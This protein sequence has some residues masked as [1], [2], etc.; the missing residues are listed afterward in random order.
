M[1]HAPIKTTLAVLCAVALPLTACGG[2]TKQAASVETSA[3]A[4][5]SPAEA[6]A[7]AAAATAAASASAAAA[8]K[9]ADDAAAKKAADDAAAKKAADDAA[10]KKAADD[11][12]AAEALKPHVYSGTGDDVLA[13]AKHGTGAEVLTI[14][15]NGG[16]NFAVEQLD[17]SMKTTGLLVNT[18]GNYTGTVLLD[19][20]SYKD[21][22]TKTLKITAGGAWTITATP[23]SALPKYD[24]SVPITGT[25]DSVFN[26]TGQARGATF[27]HNG[28]HNVAV[29]A[30]TGSSSGPDLL[31]N[32]I[33]TYTG[34]VVWA[35]GLYVVTADGDW[36]ATIK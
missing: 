33:G 8:K 25:G 15:H 29:E 23:T 34:T 12:A 5:V 20:P 2:G 14:T 11:A 36:S 19:A 17:A 35:P 9:A 30:Y 6:S 3:P 1:S 26:Y 31:V 27:T 10:A 18:I 24:G 21:T 32:E 7:S 13:I 4:T 22:D 16:H 28:A